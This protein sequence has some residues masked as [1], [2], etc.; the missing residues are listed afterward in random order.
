MAPIDLP[1]PDDYYDIAIGAFS[2]DG[3]LYGLPYA[4]EGMALFRNTDLVPDA[5]ATFDDLLAACDALGDAIDNCLGV[6][7][8]D[9]YANQAFVQGFGGYVF[10]YTR[11]RVRPDR[12][13][14]RQ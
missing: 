2:I 7:A 9:A 8:G 12:R 5:P 1:N 6:P 10:G 11:D 4:V 13:W 3:T 14:P